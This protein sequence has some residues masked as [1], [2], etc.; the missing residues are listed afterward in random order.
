MF[1]HAAVFVACSYALYVCDYSMPASYRTTWFVA[2]VVT[3]YVV[4]TNTHAWFAQ[5]Y[6]SGFV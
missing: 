3:Y 2:L 1:I 4:A 6:P 5:E